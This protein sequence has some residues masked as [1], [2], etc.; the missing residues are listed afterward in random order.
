MIVS[1]LAGKP[2]PRAIPVD[3]PRLVTACYT[4]MPDPAEAWRRVIFGASRHQGSSL[5]RSF[6]EWHML[7][8]S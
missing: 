5:E 8:I 3:I 2:A 7:A 1:P 6:N 4:G